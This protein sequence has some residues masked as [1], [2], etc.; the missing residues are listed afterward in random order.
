M[1]KE[2]FIEVTSKELSKYEYDG[3]LTYRGRYLVFIMEFRMDGFAKSAFYT[4]KND[5]EKMF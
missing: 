3:E 1:D 5:K 4:I 2:E